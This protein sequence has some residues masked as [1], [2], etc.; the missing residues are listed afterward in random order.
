MFFLE[1]CEVQKNPCIAWR[2]FACQMAGC[3]YFLV[4]DGFWGWWHCLGGF[5]VHF[6]WRMC[7]RFV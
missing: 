3:W 6:L 5:C 4:K 2:W 7:G 1:D